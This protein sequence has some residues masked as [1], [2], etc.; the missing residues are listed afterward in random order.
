MISD[1][2]VR[3]LEKVCSLCRNAAVR[4]TEGLEW[5]P[6]GRDSIRLFH[7]QHTHL[8]Q[9]HSLQGLR[10]S[11]MCKVSETVVS[12][13]TVGF[14]LRVNDAGRQFVLGYW[15]HHSQHSLVRPTSP[16]CRA[17]ALSNP[18]GTTTPSLVL[19]IKLAAQGEGIRAT[20]LTCL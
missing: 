12:L 19:E 14:S 9:I 16:H 15:C 20:D 2:L 11:S 10:S 18:E 3:T 7:A 6:W 5:P 17:F 1:P 13:T 4:E 8:C